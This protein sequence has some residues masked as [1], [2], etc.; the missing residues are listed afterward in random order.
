MRLTT[1]ILL[2]LLLVPGVV[3]A[4]RPL[5]PTSASAVLDRAIARM[6]GDSTLRSIH[7]LRLEVLTQWVR[8]NFVTQPFAD[9]PSYERSDELRDYASRAWRHTRS[10]VGA[11]PAL[12]IT[13]L[14][15]D[16]VAARLMPRGP[17]APP[18]WGPL[19]L[20]YVDERRELFAFAP[21]RLLLTLRDDSGV[22]QLA[23]TTMDGAPHA[24]LQATVDGWP[25][26]VFVR[27][28][29]ALPVMVRF[30]ADE[31]NDFGLAA[32]GEHEVEFWYS[33]WTRVAPGVLLPRQRDVRRVGSPYKRMTILAMTVNAPAP[34]DSFAISDSVQSA[35]FTTE[36]RAMWDVP[37]ARTAREVDGTFAVV[38][39]FVGSAGAV[40]IGGKWVVFET[41]VH[42]GVMPGLAEWLATLAP[43][44]PI[45][46]GIATNGGAMNGAARWFAAQRIP[47]LAAPAAEPVL[48]IATAG[49]AG[50]TIITTPRWIRIGTDS[51]WVEPVTAPD[52][53]QVL[54]VYS[55]TLRW[56]YL[57][58]AGS[59]AQQAEQEAITARLAARGLMVE[60]VGSVRGVV[61]R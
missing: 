4:Q 49:R 26:T 15:R 7:S 1:S 51:L 39:P 21:E 46:A 41:A 61:T 22:R 58:F 33:Q 47:M 44:A 36:R 32:W 2:H 18:Q 25:T 57:P 40:R 31:R 27:L 60:R 52:F 34:A 11:G 50:A 16:T 6:G 23:D 13:D 54:A 20:A 14:V 9:A 29:D 19:N 56:L 59:P 38:P 17:N 28:A 8:T 48:R 45:G 53:S 37:L 43:A 55:P 10:F 24:R 35:Y 5:P 42:E 12:S 3:P 30:R